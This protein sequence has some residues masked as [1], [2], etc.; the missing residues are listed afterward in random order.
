MIA[1]KTVEMQ[2]NPGRSF[3]EVERI[4]KQT[5]SLNDILWIDT[6]GIPDDAHSFRCPIPSTE[7]TID[8]GY[9]TSIATGG[10]VDEIVRFVNKDTV[11]LAEVMKCESDTALGKAAQQ[12]IDSILLSIESYTKRTGHTLN[13][14]RIP[15][16]PAIWSVCGPDSCIHEVL[17]DLIFDNPE[18][19]K[20]I[21]E[22]KQPIRVI[23]SASYVNYLVTNNVVLVAKYWK[24]G[25]DDSY[26]LADDGAVKTLKTAFP[27]RTVVQVDVEALNYLGGGMNCISQQQPI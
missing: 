8:K 3:D 18:A 15:L 5:F 12:A 19:E 27:K 11:I 4:L 17:R 25:R 6:D 26:R 10:H 1:N 24:P 23:A 22:N 2:R 7:A 16:P 20:A 13:I 21:V 9:F 14:L